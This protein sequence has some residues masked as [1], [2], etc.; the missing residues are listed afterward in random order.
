MSSLLTANSIVVNCTLN[1]GGVFRWLQVL[2][3]NTH[4]LKIKL[5]ANVLIALY[6]CGHE[7]EHA[8]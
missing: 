4:F 7:K 5:S 1:T 8:N 6:F 3:K 2:L